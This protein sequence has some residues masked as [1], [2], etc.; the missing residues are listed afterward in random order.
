[1]N[2]WGYEERK[3]LIDNE[4]GSL[5]SKRSVVRIHSGVPNYLLVFQ[6]ISGAFLPLSLFPSNLQYAEEYD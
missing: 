1:V 6:L 4:T 3:L 2:E 5:R